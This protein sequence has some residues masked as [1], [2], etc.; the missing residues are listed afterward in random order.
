MRPEPSTCLV[1][2]NPRHHNVQEDEGRLEVQ[3]DGQR[4][5]STGGRL[6]R[7]VLPQDF[8]QD[9]DISGMVIH[10]KNTGVT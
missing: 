7:I 8:F 6:Q 2:P 5:F 9:G 1:A 10:H 3:R 4:L